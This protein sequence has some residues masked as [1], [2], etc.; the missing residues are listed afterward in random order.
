VKRYGLDARQACI[1]FLLYLAGKKIMDTRERESFIYI[2]IYI[3]NENT[4][5]RDL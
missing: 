2:Y 5:K 1:P 4:F 3:Y